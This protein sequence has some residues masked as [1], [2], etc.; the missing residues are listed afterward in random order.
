MQ[1]LTLALLLLLGL[2]ACGQKGPLYLPDEP[3]TNQN[4]TQTEPAPAEANNDQRN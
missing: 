2:A 1:R 4:Q 3:D